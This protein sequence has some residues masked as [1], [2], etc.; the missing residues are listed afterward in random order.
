MLAPSLAPLTSVVRAST[1]ACDAALLCDRLT[2]VVLR[3]D[4]GEAEL[5]VRP[6]SGFPPGGSWAAALFTEYHSPLLNDWLQLS[7][8]EA[9]MCKIRLHDEEGELEGTFDAS[10]AA[11]ADDKSKTYLCKALGTCS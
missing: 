2:N 1:G 5:F 3:F 8:D 6:M 7:V 11:Y 10:L 9:L 4:D